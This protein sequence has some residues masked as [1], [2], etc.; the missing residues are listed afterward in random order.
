[1]YYSKRGIIRDVIVTAVVT[2]I[3]FVLWYAWGGFHL[4]SLCVFIAMGNMKEK[5]CFV[6]QMKE[7]EATEANN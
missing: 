2:I 7:K 3:F 1:M 6:S 4:F 5:V